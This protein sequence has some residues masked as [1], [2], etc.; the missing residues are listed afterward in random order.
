MASAALRSQRRE[1]EAE[2]ADLRNQARSTYQQI[3]TVEREERMR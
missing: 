2:I 1:L 3:K